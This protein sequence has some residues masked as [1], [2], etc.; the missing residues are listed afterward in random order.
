MDA[1]FEKIKQ[2]NWEG[3]KRVFSDSP[4]NTQIQ[5]LPDRCVS[6]GNFRPSAAMV[7][8]YHAHPTTIKA[9]KKELWIAGEEVEFFTQL[10][11]CQGCKRQLDI[12]FWH[13]CPY[14]E[15]S[16]PKV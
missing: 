6:P 1:K 14:C 3:Q 13:F 4:T 2:E 15:N 10:V 5:I 12:Q 11:E 8:V 7:G 9:L 16:L